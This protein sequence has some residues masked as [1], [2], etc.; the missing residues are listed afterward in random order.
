MEITVCGYF[1]IA[2][3]VKFKTHTKHDHSFLAGLG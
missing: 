2:A 3:G 1:Y